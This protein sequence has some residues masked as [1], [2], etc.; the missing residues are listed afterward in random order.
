MK[1]LPQKI[2]QCYSRSTVCLHCLK[3]LQL[4]ISEDIIAYWGMSAKTMDLKLESL[5]LSLKPSI[6]R[7]EQLKSSATTIINQLFVS[8]KNVIHTLAIE[9]LGLLP[10]VVIPELKNLLKLDLWGF[11]RSDS[12]YISSTI[13]NG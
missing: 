6:W 7:N 8:S 2:W 10:L 11:L 12:C 5:A 13:R 4:H 9:P 3:I 1:I